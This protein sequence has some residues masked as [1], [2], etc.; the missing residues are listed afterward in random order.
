MAYDVKDARE[1]YENDKSSWSTVYDEAKADLAFLSPG[2]QWDDTARKNRETAKL[3]A[4]EIDQ[5]TQY[6][7]QVVN[8]NRMN[9]PSINVLPVDD[10]GDIETAKAYKGLIRHI[11]YA[12][13]ADAARDTAM[14]YAV[15]CG[16]GFTRIDHKYSALTGFEQELLIKRV[17]NPFA[18]YM[19]S[20][21]VECDGS[22]AMRGTILDVYDKKRFE[23]EYPDKKF[24]SFDGDGKT[25]SKDGEMINIAEA[26]RI[27]EIPVKQALMMDGKVLEYKEGAM[28]GVKSVRT[29]KKRKVYRCKM[30]GDETLEETYFPGLYVP[31][32]PYFGEEVW[33]DGKRELYSLIRRSKDAQ[34]RF[35]MWASKE[36]ELL[37]KAPTAPV[38]AA[39][40]QLKGFENEWKNPEGA[41]VL[42]YNLVDAMGKEVG[43][44][45]RL[46]PPPIPTGIINAMQGAGEQIKSTL[47]MYDASVGNRSNEVSGVAIEQRQ[48]KG[49]VATFHFGDNAVRSVTHEGRILV[50]AIPEIYDTE[51]TIRIIGDE[52]EPKM[53]GI[54]GKVVEKQK[55]TFNLSQGQYDVRVT[56]G[57]NFTTKRQESSQLMQEVMKNP[58]LMAVAGD[59]AFKYSDIAG[60]DALAARLKKTIPPQLMEPEDGE[61]GP[62]PQAI[63][64]QKQIEELQAAIQQMQEEAQGIVQEN[65]TLK[66][67]AA[68]KQGEL[69]I[70]QQEVDLKAKELDI[71]AKDTALQHLNAPQ[72]A[73]SQVAPKGQ[74]KMNEQGLD[75]PAL[76]QLI[77]RKKQEQAQAEAEAQAQ[78]E[79]VQMA[80]MQRQAERLQDIELRQAA[81]QQNQFLAEQIIGAIG[82][83]T[84]AIQTPKQVQ[85]DEQGRVVGVH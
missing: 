76:E 3:P 18:V 55:Q 40:G 48:R 51:R 80:E 23:A 14:E 24:I 73:P 31:I 11:E 33:R 19:D 58:N 50:S 6:V 2:G 68:N 66:V 37:L 4:L 69:D 39:A 34:R 83:L 64:A 62:S 16:I 71:K 27:E 60:A 7:H 22:D 29:Y 30:S 75:I 9:T 46:A 17:A 57:P 56:T 26:F 1:A 52:D 10:E 78:A 38:M 65:Q 41:A 79:Q 59:L 85:R 25:E 74:G 54:N 20:S 43:P 44:P 84:Q 49:D 8:E 61:D 21:I 45:Q 70:K 81:M 82:Q 12:S 13:M 67:Q 47:G 72:S 15:K 32:I 63:Q 77:E 53:V 36:M 5:L 35:N 28:D 42:Q